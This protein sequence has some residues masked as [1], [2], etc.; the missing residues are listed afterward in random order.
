MLQNEGEKIKAVGGERS[1]PD[2]G[3]YQKA[4]GSLWGHVVSKAIGASPRRVLIVLAI[5]SVSAFVQVAAF[6]LLLSIAEMISQGGPLQTPFGTKV[7]ATREAIGLGVVAVGLS[8][9][10]AALAKFCLTWITANY[11]KRFFGELISK[12]LFKLKELRAEGAPIAADDRTLARMMKRECRY[13]SRSYVT[14]LQALSPLVI[15]LAVLVFSLFENPAITSVVILGIALAA[16]L[17]L[18]LTSWGAG[19]SDELMMASREKAQADQAIVDSIVRAP[20]FSRR[21]PEELVAYTS[22]PA[23]DGF[24]EAYRNRMRVGA[25][26]QFLSSGVGVIVMGAVLLLFAEGYLRGFLDLTD[27]VFLLVLFRLLLTNAASL[28]QSLTLI[29]SYEP[30]VRGLLEVLSHEPARV[31]QR[32]RKTPPASQHCIV[33]SPSRLSVFEANRLVRELWRRPPPSTVP[34]VTGDYGLSSKNPKE[35]LGVPAGTGIAQILGTTLGLS[36]DETEKLSAFLSRETV[37]PDDWLELPD[38]MKF[39]LAFQAACRRP[40]G[41]IVVDGPG[42]NLLSPS[43]RRGLLETAGARRLVLVFPSVPKRVGLAGDTEIFIAE[44]DELRAVGTLKG[45]TA[46]RDELQAQLKQL[47]V[48]TPDDTELDGSESPAPA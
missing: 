13:L 39:S 5:S 36:D 41:I 42:F 10:I 22:S 31:H 44:P 12:L 45:L 1:Q 29:G 23:V 18:K 3:A 2:S 46:Q 34:F 43:L 19:V 48:T 26:S 24:L 6:A 35:A 27:A 7:E 30:F 11:R 20:N 25:L 38:S 21:S 15:L 17:H 33:L 16:P 8:L 47:Q 28:A 14:A 32:R 37:E 4:I 9:L 40:L